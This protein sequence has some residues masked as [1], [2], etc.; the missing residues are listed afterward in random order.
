MRYVMKEKLF[1]WGDDYTIHDEQGRDVFFVDGKALSFGDQLS[2]Q[3]M[4]GNELAFIKEKVFTWGK[5]FEIYRNGKLAAVVNKELFTLFK[6][7]FTVDVPGPGD[8]EAHGDFLDYE[9][10]FTRGEETVAAVSKKWFS[11]ADTYGVDIADGE[12]AVLILASVVVVD[13]ACHSDRK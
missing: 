8:L 2:F 4:H 13:Q 10:K 6:C 9:Y 1:S 7:R 5:T 3:D 11:W 12:D